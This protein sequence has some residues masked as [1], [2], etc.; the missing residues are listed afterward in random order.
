MKWYEHMEQVSSF[1]HCS[2]SDW[3]VKGSYSGP[4][5]PYI[6]TIS[7]LI[8]LFLYTEDGGGMSPGT[9]ENMYQANTHCCEDIKPYRNLL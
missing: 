4:H 3:F 5:S 1:F 7:S 2:Y 9:L 6:H 8:S